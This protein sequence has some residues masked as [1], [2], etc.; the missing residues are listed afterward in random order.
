MRLG[1][2]AHTSCFGLNSKRICLYPNQGT[3]CR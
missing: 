2:D 1:R 3:C